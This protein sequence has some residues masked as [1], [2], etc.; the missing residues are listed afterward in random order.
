MD[1]EKGQWLLLNWPAFALSA[2]SSL[3]TVQGLQMECTSGAAV[4]TTN[5]RRV[6]AELKLVDFE[7]TI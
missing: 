7:V 4:S 2:V 1:D 6:T 5:G 3:I